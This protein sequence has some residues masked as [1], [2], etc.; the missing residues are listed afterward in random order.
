MELNNR[1][2][3]Y[4]L[5]NNCALDNRCVSVSAISVLGLI[6]PGATQLPKVND[7]INPNYSYSDCSNLYVLSTRW[8]FLVSPV[9]AYRRTMGPG[10]EVTPTSSL[11]CPDVIRA[12]IRLQIVARGMK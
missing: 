4:R 6:L 2:E 5:K 10:G 11:A 7:S 1:G 3:F 9:E 12:Y 8:F